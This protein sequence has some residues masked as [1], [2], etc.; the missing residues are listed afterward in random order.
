MAM[1]VWTGDVD[2]YSEIP[3]DH[4]QRHPVEIGLRSA[5]SG[6]R[7]RWRVKILCSK[8]EEWWA[9]GVEGPRFEWTAF[10]KEPDEQTASF[11]TGRIME[12]LK[13]G[14]VLD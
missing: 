4:A 14:G 9:V 13:E 10:L 5:L 2:V 7:G 12:A 1:V 3:S 8:T 11:I 6:L